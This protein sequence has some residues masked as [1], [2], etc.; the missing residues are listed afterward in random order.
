MIDGFDGPSAIKEEKLV[1]YPQT[2]TRAFSIYAERNLA[3]FNQQ[4]PV[5]RLVHVFRA[6]PLSP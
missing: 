3:S 5:L 4:I 6:W 1:S 2:S